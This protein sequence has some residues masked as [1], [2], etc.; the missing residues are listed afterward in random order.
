MKKIYL[1]LAL[2]CLGINAEAQ[3][4]QSKKLEGGLELDV[5]PFATGGYFGAAWMGKDLW[6]V[7]ALTAFVKKPD[8]S[9]KSGFSNH[10]IT[11]YALV[12]DLF[13]KKDWKG[14]WIGAGLVY[15][16]SS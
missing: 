15:W 2:F 10:Q 14:W 7:R 8:W 13:L 9:T 4:N 1:V 16:N 12:V 11:A 3:S 5:L 6:R